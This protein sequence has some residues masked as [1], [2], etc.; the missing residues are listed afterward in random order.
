M[1]TL[2]AVRTNPWLRTFYA[3]LR[4]KGKLPKVALIAAER[5]LLTAVYC[6]AKNRRPFVPKLT[7]TD[8]E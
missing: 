3:R 5:K 2:G 8:E 1:A 7:T 4:G 6:V